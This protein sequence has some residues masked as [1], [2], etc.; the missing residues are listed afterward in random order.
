MYLTLPRHLKQEVTMKGKNPSILFKLIA[1]LLR[2]KAVCLGACLAMI[3]TSAATLS[4]GYGVRSLVD[5]GFSQGSTHALTNSTYIIIG[6]ALLMAVGTFLRFYLALW[7][8]ERVSADLRSSVFKHLLTLHPSYFE[9]NRSG[10]IMSRLTTDTTMIQ[11]VIGASASKALRSI[12]VVTGGMIM[13]LI[14]NLKLTAVVLLSVPVLL[15]PV[16]FLGNRIRILARRSQDVVA[17]VGSYAGEVIQQIKTVQSYT[18]EHNERIRFDG[19]VEHVF[20]VAKDRIKHRGLMMAIVLSL[21]ITAIALVL[22]VGGNDVI[23]GTMT[24]GDL[25]A[26]IFYAL[27]VSASFATFSQVIG[28]VQ[29]AVGAAERLFELMNVKSEITSPSSST[30]TALRPTLEL[31]GVTFYYPSRPDNAALKSLNLSIKSGQSLALV[32]PSGSGKTT[33]FELL[34]RFYDPQEGVIKLDGVDIKNL[35]TQYLRQHLAVVSQQPS[36]FSNDVMY[37]IRYGRPEASDE[38]VIEAAKAANAHEFIEQL[39][40]GYSSFLGEQGVRL[41][42]GQRQRIAIARAILKDP[43]ILLLDEATSALDAESEFR[44]QQALDNLMENRTTLIIAHR[45]ATIRN[46]DQ[47]AVMEAGELKEIGK[48]QELLETSALY[49]R[50]SELQFQNA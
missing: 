38:E 16:L 40:E 46:V 3:F 2:Y 22:W 28:E 37:N 31:E 43:A 18:Q 14:T 5:N 24:A 47:I 30:E 20:T 8:A 45:L 13:L 15:V 12:L 17:D 19:H 6:I 7:L 49:K 11:T 42:G 39:P 48:H 32:G 33:T 34:Q 44:V 50:L 36:L 29:K 27:L 9:E 26:F 25:A 4:L 41:S 21:M 23:N 1:Y 10:E 35:P